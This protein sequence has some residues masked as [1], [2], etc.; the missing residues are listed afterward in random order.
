M[1]STIGLERITG[2]ALMQIKY[3]IE[4]N[5]DEM[6]KKKWTTS[7]I[8]IAKPLIKGGGGGGHYLKLPKFKHIYVANITLSPFLLCRYF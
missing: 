7:V 2:L 3:R 5:L 6:I 8:L 1:C 4:L